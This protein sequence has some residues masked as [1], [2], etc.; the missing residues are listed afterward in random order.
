MA[1]VTWIG[2]SGGG[3]GVSYPDPLN[4]DT[5]N[6]PTSMDVVIIGAGATVDVYEYIEFVQLNLAG[7]LVFSNEG[8][9]TGNNINVGSTGVLRFYWQ[10]AFGAGAV[11][12]IASGGL[13]E[14][15]GGQFVDTATINV[16]AGGTLLFEGGYAGST[17]NITLQGT[18]TFSVGSASLSTP[19]V[20]Q[21]G[22]A[23]TY[24]GGVNTFATITVQSG[25]TLDWSSISENQSGVIDVQ[26][27][28]VCNFYNTAKNSGSLTF[29]SGS[30]G[31]F[32]GSSQ[33]LGALT[34]NSGGLCS[35]AGGLQRGNVFGTGVIR[36]PT[37]V[38]LMRQLN[39]PGGRTGT[40]TN[41]QRPT[42]F[43]GGQL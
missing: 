29:Q 28:A 18:C 41:T 36:F 33:N 35:F 8:A 12:N 26:G 16:S 5:G 40:A 30:T 43:G 22:G 6:V 9:S 34:V 15:I 10:T 25:G 39:G 17:G 14:F 27:G 13:C 2:I 3:D 11:L 37:I 19:I 7:T 42:N 20:V 1:T 38:D 23:L 4:W 31:V 32:S 21:S 24:S